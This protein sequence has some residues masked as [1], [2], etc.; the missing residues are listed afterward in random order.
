M[1]TQ[2]TIKV[3]FKVVNVS[4]K[5]K[6]SIF[7]QIKQKS[8]NLILKVVMVKNV[9]NIFFDKIEDLSKINFAQKWM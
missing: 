9:Y 3:Y 7:W 5:L 2:L 6:V 8:T 1:Q 4:K